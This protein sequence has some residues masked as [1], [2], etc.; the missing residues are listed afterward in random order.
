MFAIVLY[1]VAL[2]RKIYGCILDYNL[3][4]SDIYSCD[5]IDL[6]RPGSF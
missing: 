4:I 1:S 2:G 3:G 6:I 5:Y